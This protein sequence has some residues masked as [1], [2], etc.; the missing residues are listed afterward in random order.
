[1]NKLRTIML[2]PAALILWCGCAQAATCDLTEFDQGA[3]T[4]IKSQVSNQYAQFEWASDADHVRNLNWLWHYIANRGTAGLGALW[5]KAEIEI[6][7]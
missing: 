3:P 2:A 1:M 5:R 6:S 7:I 4:A